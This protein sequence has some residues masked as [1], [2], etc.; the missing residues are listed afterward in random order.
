MHW[1][2]QRRHLAASSRFARKHRVHSQTLGSFSHFWCLSNLL[3]AAYGDSICFATSIFRMDSVDNCERM[4]TKLVSVGNSLRRFF[5]YW[6]RKLGPQ[7]YLI[8]TTSQLS[9][10]F[11]GQH[12]RR[13][14]WYR[15]S[16]NGIGN[17]EGS[18]TSSQ[19]SMNFGPLTDKIGP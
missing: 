8:S 16:G 13:E 11:E 10:N 18:H 12:L 6:P 5:G 17:D 1:C 15:Q 9:G 19:N 14:T 3:V 4:F 7:N 2:Q